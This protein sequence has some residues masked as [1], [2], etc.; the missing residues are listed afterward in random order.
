MNRM[1]KTICAVSACGTF[2]DVL[3]R[4]TNGNQLSKAESTALGTVSV[5]ILAL[6]H[7]VSTKP[8]GGG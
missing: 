5:T 7:T 4:K 1:R 6:A 8:V 2:S 3:A